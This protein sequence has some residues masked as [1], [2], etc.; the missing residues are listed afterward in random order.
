MV[1]P[2][3]GGVE[4][5]FKL[6]VPWATVFPPP[7]PLCSFGERFADVLLCS[8]VVVFFFFFFSPLRHCSGP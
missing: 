5:V 7:P 1:V 6:W 4:G 3:Y 2:R 8:V